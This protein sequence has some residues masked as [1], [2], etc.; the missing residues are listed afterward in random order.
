MA[1]TAFEAVDHLTVGHP[2]GLQDTTNTATRVRSPLVIV[3]NH[4][5]LVA[6]LR[7]LRD[8]SR[9]ASLM[10]HSDPVLAPS[11]LI[12]DTTLADKQ[13]RAVNGK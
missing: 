13:G 1:T 10:K 9:L 11:R 6:L 8:L 4:L 2:I 7:L 5:Y 3:Q 12:L